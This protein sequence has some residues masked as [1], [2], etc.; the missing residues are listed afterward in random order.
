MIYRYSLE[1]NQEYSF[2]AHNGVFWIT[3][4]ND[5]LDYVLNFGERLEI[6]YK[7]GL[8]LVQ[9][10]QGD[11][12]GFEFLGAKEG[13]IHVLTHKAQTKCA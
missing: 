6:S 13:K 4:E 7:K 9:C 2:V 5:S 1:E 12:G 10:L 11:I 8:M 3:F